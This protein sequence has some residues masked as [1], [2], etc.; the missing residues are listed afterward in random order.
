MAFTPT[1][2]PPPLTSYNVGINNLHD[3]LYTAIKNK[4]YNIHTKKEKMDILDCSTCADSTD[5]NGLDSLDSLGLTFSKL[6]GHKQTNNMYKI[7]VYNV[8][9]CN[10][11]YNNA[12]LN[13]WLLT[14]DHK[15]SCNSLDVPP[16]SWI[17]LDNVLTALKNSF[18]FAY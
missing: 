5:L 8:V 3:N 11:F 14:T 13:G 1:V 15:Y 17:S 10:S 18:F 4:Q 12:L 9:D 16:C 7:K 6:L 2:A